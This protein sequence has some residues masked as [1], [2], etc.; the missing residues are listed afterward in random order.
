MNDTFTRRR[1]MPKRPAAHAEAMREQILEGGRRAFIAGGFRGTSVPS[2]AAEAGVSVGLIYR[3][4]PSKE[5]L[6]LE[7]CI[8]GT[9]AELE[10]LA[11]RIA[12]ID[13]PGRAPDG[14]DRLLLRCP[15]PRDRRAARAPGARRRPV[16]RADPGGAPPPRRRPARLL[17]RVRPGRDRARRA[18]IRRAMSTR[19]PP[20]RRCCWTARSS[21]SPS[22]ATPSTGTRSATGSS[23]PSSPCPGLHPAA[24]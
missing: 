13:G 5:E 6:F 14:R 4:F 7:L 23:G 21:P 3:Y 16:R 17:G 24:R 12:P 15:V 20:P 18:A 19:S 2:I 11:E 1:P 9:P 10:D 8:S 22:R